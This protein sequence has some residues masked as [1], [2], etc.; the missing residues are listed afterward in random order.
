LRKEKNLLI[1]WRRTF[2]LATKLLLAI[3]IYMHACL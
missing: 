3:Y 2:F 1:Y